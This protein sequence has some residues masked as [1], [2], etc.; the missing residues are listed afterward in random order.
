MPLRLAGVVG[1]AVLLLTAAAPAPAQDNVTVKVVA[2]PRDKMPK[3]ADEANK[4]IDQLYKQ[5]IQQ[6]AIRPG[7]R[8]VLV[9]H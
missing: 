4:I 1:L 2:W 6:K 3:T 7:T 9:P 8:I 5:F